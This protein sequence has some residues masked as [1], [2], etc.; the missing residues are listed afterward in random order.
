[1]HFFIQINLNPAAQIIQALQ[2]PHLKKVKGHGSVADGSNEVS[3]PSGFEGFSGSSGSSGSFEG[4]F[5]DVSGLLSAEDAA[6]D[7]C[8]DEDVGD[9][10]D[11]CDGDADDV[12]DGVPDD[13]AGVELTVPVPSCQPVLSIPLSFIYSSGSSSS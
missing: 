2:V 4:V 5:D 8:A 13:A 9:D 12:F 3:V 1:M 11:A 6:D 10:D 7:D